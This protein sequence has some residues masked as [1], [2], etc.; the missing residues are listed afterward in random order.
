M[1][2]GRSS[3]L[4]IVLAD[5]RG[6]TATIA[7]ELGGWLLRYVRAIEAFGP[8]DVLHY[9]E[10]CEDRYPDMHVGSPL[11][12]PLAG[13]C[14][15]GGRPDRYVWEGVE[16]S[17]PLH[18]FARRLPWRVED[19]SDRCATLTLVPGPLTR[20][21]YPFEFY[22]SLRYELNDGAL[23]ARLTVTNDGDV[24]MPLNAG[25]HPYIRTPLSPGG[26]RDCCFVILPES[27]EFTM[28]PTGLHISPHRSSPCLRATDIG[29]PAR[30]FGYLADFR[31]ELEDRLGG[32]T[33]SIW[34]EIGAPF[35]FL[36]TWSPDEAAPFC[37]VEPRTALPEP[38]SP[39]IRDQLIVLA[40]GAKFIAT[41]HLDA[42]SS[43]KDRKDGSSSAV[44]SS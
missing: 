10:T 39:E 25:F 32:V 18:G 11:M 21:C 19:T 29:A 43:R 44:G 5:D 35:E 16:R 37:C 27:R 24:P 33:I 7:P 12:F 14:T 6:N 22:L 26:R 4:K 41:M 31:A 20:D 42:F 40:P 1:N 15:S 9:E 13:Y 17:M 36:T 34:A 38:F 2:S 8:V 28:T 30:H 23:V 3:V